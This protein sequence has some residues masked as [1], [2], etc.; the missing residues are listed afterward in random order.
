LQR[1]DHAVRG[2]AGD[3]AFDRTLIAMLDQQPGVLRPSLA[4]ALQAHDHPG[5]VH[6]F[7]F[8]D[9]LQLTLGEGLANVFK[10]LFRRQSPRT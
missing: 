5:G 9:E 10:S 1:L 8:H 2:W 7:A 6:P 4:V 3:V